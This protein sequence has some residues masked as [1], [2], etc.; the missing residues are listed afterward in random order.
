LEVKRDGLGGECLELGNRLLQ[1][2]KKNCDVEH[3]RI[4][5]Y[6]LPINKYCSKI[7]QET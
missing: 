2:E 7:L 5:G 4:P 1:K 6:D 3:E